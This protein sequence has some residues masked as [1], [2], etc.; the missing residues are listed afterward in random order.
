MIMKKKKK[1]YIAPKMEVIELDAPQLMLSASGE[2][3]STGTGNG[4]ATDEDPELANG[5]RGT[6]G[7]LWN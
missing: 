6:W 1:K 5:R 3:G 7:S 2:T 4:E